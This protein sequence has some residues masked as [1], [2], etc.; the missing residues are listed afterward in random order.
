M[1]TTAIRIVVLGGGPAGYLGA[2]RAAQL[3]ASVTLVEKDHCGG[4][5]LNHG[6]IPTK[7]L[8]LS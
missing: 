1:A 3:G 5:C 2:L 4:A 7:A 8:L 6:C